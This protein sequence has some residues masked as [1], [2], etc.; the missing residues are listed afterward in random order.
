MKKIILILVLFSLTGCYNYKELNGLAIATGFAVDIVNDEYEVTILIS[1]SQKQSSGESKNSASAVVY[2]GSGK[3]IF[4][5]IKD[6][7]L[8]ISKEIYISHI[9]VRVLS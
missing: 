2:K 3:T 6:A 9:E 4:E 7:S 5:A 8:A 1:N